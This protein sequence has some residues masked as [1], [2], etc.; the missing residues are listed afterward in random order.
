MEKCLKRVKLCKK[1]AFPFLD[2][3]MMWNAQG[4]LR[5]GVFHKDGQ[6]IKYVDCSSCY[7]PCT[8]KSIMSGVYLQLGRLTSKMV[9]N[10]G[11]R[12]DKNYPEHAEALL[13][14]DMGP[15]KFPTLDKIWERETLSKICT[16]KKCRDNRRT[17]F[18]IGYSNFLNKAKTPEL[19]RKLK[20]QYNLPWLCVSVA[21]RQFPNTCKNFSRDLS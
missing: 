16:K 13:A 10:G 8:F 17:F 9:E 4:F 1:N 12:L 21:H 20:E 2:M 6:A 11:K 15:I 18:V 5:F 19:I 7:R 3:K 14:A